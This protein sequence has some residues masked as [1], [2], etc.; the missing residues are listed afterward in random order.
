MTSDRI[1][2]GGSYNTV[3]DKNRNVLGLEDRTNNGIES[4]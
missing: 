2:V 1:L 3:S 4:G